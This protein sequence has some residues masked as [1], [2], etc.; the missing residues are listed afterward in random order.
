MVPGI[1][2]EPWQQE[3][4]VEDSYVCHRR[5][6][7]ANLKMA[8]IVPSV[9]CPTDLFLHLGPHFQNFQNLQK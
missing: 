7:T 4:L 3:H 8:R 9:S 6:E 2:V 1:K 5:Q